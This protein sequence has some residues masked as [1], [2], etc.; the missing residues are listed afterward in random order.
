MCK[1]IGDRGTDDPAADDNDPRPARAALARAG[2]R[3][4]TCSHAAVRSRSPAWWPEAVSAS[5]GHA[6]R[7]YSQQ[8]DG[9]GNRGESASGEL[10][11]GDAVR[12]GG[13]GAEPLDLVLL[14]G[15][16]VALEPEPVRATLPGQDVRGDPVEKPPVVA[17]DDRTAGEL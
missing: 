7:A 3:W 12:T 4:L 9:T 15:V 5:G 2:C 16:E 17:G 11:V 8:P 14:V 1:V 6:D 10:A 13:F